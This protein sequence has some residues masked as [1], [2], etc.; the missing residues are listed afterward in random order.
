[1]AKKQRR[2]KGKGK[3]PRNNNSTARAHEQAYRRRQIAM[4]SARGHSN[5]E[6]R[7]RLGIAP[8]TLEKD[9]RVIREQWWEHT[10]QDQGA[11]ARREV[12][13]LEQTRSQA[14]EDYFTQ[15]DRDGCTHQPQYLQIWLR[16][17]DQLHQLERLND[18]VGNQMPGQEGA[19]DQVVE[20]A[21]DT[22]EQATAVSEGVVDMDQLARMATRNGGIKTNER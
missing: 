17:T 7:E 21:V 8:Q 14:L 12:Q 1:M 19:S 6:I 22:Q 4:Y 20:V 2:D 18:S 9:L 16:I 15:T 11:K 5:S 10:Q 13:L 3:G